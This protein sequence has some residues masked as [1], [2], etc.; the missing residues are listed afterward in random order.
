[1]AFIEWTDDL[2]LGIDV[3]DK[4]HMRIAD[5]INRMHEAI[6]QD[7]QLAIKTLFD[8]VIDYSVTHF[9]F[10]EKLQRKAGYEYCSGHMRVHMLFVKKIGEYKKRFDEGDS[11]IPR[12]V[13]LMLRKWLINHIQYDDADFAPSVMK[14]MNIEPKKKGWI[15]RVFGASRSGG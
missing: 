12:Q 2:N 5:Y 13:L 7:D 14:M 10:E 3:I 4:Q 11:E 15:A 9:G 6:E 8:E 1:M